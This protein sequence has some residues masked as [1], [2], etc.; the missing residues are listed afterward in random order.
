MA[1]RRSFGQLRRLPSRRWQAFYT[2]PD[3]ALHY[4][5]STFETK[6]DAEAWLVDERRIIASG[7]WVAPA[8]RHHQQVTSRTL[9]SYAAAWLADRQLKPRTREHYQALLD[10]HI[11]PTLGDKP[12]KS[13][14]TGHHP[15]LARRARHEDTDDASPCLRAA[16]QHPGHRGP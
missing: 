7:A 3:M 6:M 1:R 9:D 10:K 14:H 15:H 4:A 16:A 2:G 8:E 13:T 12:L 11:L 5:P